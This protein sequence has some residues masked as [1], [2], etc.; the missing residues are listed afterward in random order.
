MIK[1]LF[2]LVLPLALLSNDAIESG[3]ALPDFQFQ[4]SDGKMISKGSLKKDKPVIVFYFSPDYVIT[5]DQIDHIY[6]SADDFKEVNTLW[7]SRASHEENDEWEELNFSDYDWPLNIVAR[8]T[9]TIFHELFGSANIFN[10]TV[11]D[12]KWKQ[13]AAYQEPQLT[14][15]LLEKLK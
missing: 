9:E 7:V 8:D 6:Y 10:V 13:V 14:S 3:D 15:K 5:D 2:T 1:S 12:S 4:S 11:Y